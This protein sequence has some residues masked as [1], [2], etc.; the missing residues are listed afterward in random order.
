MSDYDAHK[1]LSNTEN[2]TSYGKWKP[3]TQK[4]NKGLDKDNKDSVQYADLNN[5]DTWAILPLDDK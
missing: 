2:K 4:D 5:S 3:L 1:A